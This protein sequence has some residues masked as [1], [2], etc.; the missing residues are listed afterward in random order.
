M[1]RKKSGA[2][3]IIIFLLLVLILFLLIKKPPIEIKKEN[4]EKTGELTVY[5]I[6]KE[7]SGYVT[8]KYKFK[9]S[10]GAEKEGKGRG[11]ISDAGTE[12]VI[13]EFAYE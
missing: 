2:A 5:D 13:K 1:R 10:D 12:I 3:K 11:R 9:D 7:E 6:E 8:F 4:I